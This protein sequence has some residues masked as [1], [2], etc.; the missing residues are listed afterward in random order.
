MVSSGSDI[1]VW[2]G[3]E[4][5]TVLNRG[6]LTGSQGT[7]KTTSCPKVLYISNE[8]IPAIA[9]LHDKCQD[10]FPIISHNHKCDTRDDNDDPQV[11][12]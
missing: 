8:N 10:T 7:Y 6:A 12:V 11:Y 2:H 9:Q 1:A 5:G 3:Q 4:V